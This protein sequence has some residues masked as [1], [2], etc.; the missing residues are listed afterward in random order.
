MR[1]MLSKI[2]A[3]L[4]ILALVASIACSPA[5]AQDAEAS[6]TIRVLDPLGRP[7]EKIEVRL[8]KD[9]EVRKF[10]TN[11]T[12]YAEF[13]HLTEGE[14]VARVKLDNV[15][16]AER[17]V[18]VPGDELVELTALVSEVKLWVKNLDGG[19]V[20]GAE[21]S[22]RS[23]GGY[24]VRAESDEDG[25]VG[26]RLVPYSELEGVGSY[27]LTVKLGGVE[28]YEEDVRVNEPSF[29]KNITAP[30]LRLRLTV[31]DL[32]GRPVPRITVGLTSKSYSAKQ[33]SDN[34]TVLFENIPSSRLEGVGVYGIEARMRTEAGD[35]LIYAGNRSFTESCSLSLI[36]D[37]ARIRVRVLDEEG[38][39]VS[40][41]RIVLSNDL[42]A[43]FSSSETDEEGVAAFERVPLSQGMVKAGTY[44]VRA[45][46]AENLI[47]EVRREI[48]RDGETIE[49]R[50]ERG[51]AAIRLLDFRGNPL[52]GYLVSLVDSL[53]GERYNRT[54]DEG[55]EAA[56]KIF[57]GFYELQVYDPRG[58]LVHSQHLRLAGGKLD[59]KLKEVNFPLRVVVSDSFGNPLTSGVAEIYLGGE[60]LLRRRLSG[61]PITLELPHPAE[62]RI[63]IL[64]DEGELIQRETIYV[65]GPSTRV[66]RLEPYI[67]LGG[68]LRLEDLAQAIGFGVSA[69]I[70]AFSAILLVRGLRRKG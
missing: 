31:V 66:I 6:L 25:A 30:L 43:N 60:K 39:P 37:L 13:R 2:M 1:A 56:F 22:L 40:K 7:L 4:V 19:P 47:G 69:L 8:I 21:V 46:R 11:S 50:V 63:D 61:E 15:T 55:G 10:L 36:S 34:G 44:I 62:L 64:S 14:Y 48:L 12:G 23:A 70:L 32:E 57:Y 59:L 65:D 16:L 51:A 67:Q 28:V 18:S 38:E 54:T 5:H 49:I 17:R 45:Y 9:S 41:V 27:A 33:R 24:E 35:M 26:F 29:S 52:A 58:G 42:L 68:L 20:G 3:I 53:T